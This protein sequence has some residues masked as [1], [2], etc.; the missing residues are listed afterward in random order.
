MGRM[1]TTLAAEGE[2]R[3]D[4]SPFTRRDFVPAGSPAAPS[5][6]SCARRRAAS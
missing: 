1:L 3:F 2:I 5:R 6:H 4:M